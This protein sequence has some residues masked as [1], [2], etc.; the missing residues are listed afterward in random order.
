MYVIKFDNGLY[1]CSYNHADKQLRKATIYKSL[2]MA[3][4]TASDCMLR[5]EFISP[6]NLMKDVKSYKIVE[7]ELKE[8]GEVE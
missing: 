3:L 6:C 4:S 7:V 1:W 8:V 2:K 5:I